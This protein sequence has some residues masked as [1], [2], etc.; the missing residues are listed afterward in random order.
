[1]STE[2]QKDTHYKCAGFNLAVHTQVQ[3]HTLSHFS[4]REVVGFPLK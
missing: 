2:G 1:M 3:K 4:F